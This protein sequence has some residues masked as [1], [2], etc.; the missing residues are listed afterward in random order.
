SVTQTY[1]VTLQRPPGL[2]LEQLWDP[3]GQ[4]ESVIVA[5][6]VPGSPAE[7]S[8]VVECGDKVVA[9][10]SSIGNIMWP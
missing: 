1:E 4:A 10:S 5:G 8:G 2:I 6:I 7:A 9:V 3:A